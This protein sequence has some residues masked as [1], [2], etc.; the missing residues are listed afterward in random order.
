[1]SYNGRFLTSQRPEDT[2]LRQGRVVRLSREQ[3]C[4]RKPPYFYVFFSFCSGKGRF[5][6]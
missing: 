4:M 2:V 5:H 3:E 1:M 6:C